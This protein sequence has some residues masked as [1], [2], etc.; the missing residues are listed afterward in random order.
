MRSAT[1]EIRHGRSCWRAV[2][3]AQR[4]SL[5]AHSPQVAAQ[6]WARTTLRCNWAPLYRVPAIVSRACPLAD[7]DM[8]RALPSHGPCA[9]F[10][11]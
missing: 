5:Y 8:T 10:P 4:L 2:S 11:L 7:D 3:H 6:A 9:P 1:G